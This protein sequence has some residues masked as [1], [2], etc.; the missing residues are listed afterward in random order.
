MVS[1]RTLLVLGSLAYIVYARP[2]L[3][4]KA[5]N[6]LPSSVVSMIPSGLSSR[7]DNLGK[8][9]DNAKQ[10]ASYAK[11]AMDAFTGSSSNSDAPQQSIGF[12]SVAK[13]RNQEQQ[14][15]NLYTARKEELTKEIFD[16]FKQKTGISVRLIHDEP[17]KL[18]SRMESE[19]DDPVA[20]VFMTAD[21]VSLYVA[22]HSN[23]LDVMPGNILSLV[24]D[25]ALKN[26]YWV[27]LTKRARVFVY[28][29]ERV[30][31]KELTLLRDYTDLGLPVWQGRLL[32]RSS[33]NA[34]NQMMIAAMIYHHGVKFA[35]EWCKNIAAN[36]A[37]HPQG[38][39]TDQI[40]A[41]IAGVADL[42]VVNHY[43]YMR[44]LYEDKRQGIE[45]IGVIYP[46]QDNVG[47]SINIG[48]IG[49]LKGAKNRTAALRF[50]EFLLSSEAQ[51]ILAQKNYEYPV[52]H[53]ATLPVG[54]KETIEFKFD[55]TP[56]ND[57][58]P[59]YKEADAISVKNG[60]Y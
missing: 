2:D 11:K 38:G 58:A 47:T 13:I 46:N 5:K 59:L 52:L 57:I 6:S 53:S 20:D 15:V 19:R 3:L 17:G 39:D 37:R 22:A 29:K 55:K 24:D 49:I 10:A 33:S 16:L 35:N 21:A 45:S 14:V 7:I 27:A 28:H 43:Y 42:A 34:Y 51:N 12:L 50:I 9:V 23:Y 36:L 26:N 4:A 60:W 18:L 54:L 1:T 30:T 32:V 31:E 40:K 41:L 8:G 44:M 25:H 48:G 56:I